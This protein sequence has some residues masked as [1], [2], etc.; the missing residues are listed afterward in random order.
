M[1]SKTQ[2]IAAGAEIGTVCAAVWDMTTHASETIA[3]DGMEAMRQIGMA[4]F[5]KGIGAGGEQVGNVAAVG[6]VAGSALIA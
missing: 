5:A 1:A 2:G 3:A 4:G 6:L